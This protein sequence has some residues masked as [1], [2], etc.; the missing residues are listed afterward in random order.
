MDFRVEFKNAT[1][2]DCI[3]VIETPND[4][5]YTMWVAIDRQERKLYDVVMFDNGPEEFREGLVRV[6]RNGKMGFANNF[7]QIVIPCVYDFVWWFEKGEAKVT[8]K[9][10]KY[11]DSYEHL[12]VESDEWFV[13]DKEGKRINLE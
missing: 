7:G 4:G 5:I 13:I 10:K 12:Q 6:N 11:V 1:Y 8:H 9:A 2:A 3:H